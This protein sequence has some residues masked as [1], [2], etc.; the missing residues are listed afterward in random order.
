[1]ATR[2]LALCAGAV[3]A[4]LVPATAVAGHALDDL[5]VERLS[6]ALRISERQ[7]TTGD[8][9]ESARLD[10]AYRAAGGELRAELGHGQFARAVAVPAAGSGTCVADSAPVSTQGPDGSIQLLGPAQR[11]EYV[12]PAATTLLVDRRGRRL[13]LAWHDPLTPPVT[14]SYLSDPMLTLAVR[15]PD[16]DVPRSLISPWIA[17]SALKR[18]RLR[19]V[20]EGSR[21][22][23]TA[24][25]STVSGQ[26]S[27]R[28]TVLFRHRRPPAFA[29]VSR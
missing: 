11:L 23:G 3:L 17:A 12:R 22:W 16:A 26:A 27:W 8:D 4:L 25:G 20:I 28:L 13:R 5:S 19:V 15:V 24:A 29:G 2:L 7:C 10:V 1:V 18:S 14:C 6:G 9:C 21:R